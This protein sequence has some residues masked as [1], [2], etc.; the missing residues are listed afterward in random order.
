MQEH[1]KYYPKPETVRTIIKRRAFC[2]TFAV[3]I[4]ARFNTGETTY[5]VQPSNIPMGGPYTVTVQHPSPTPDA[6]YGPLETYYV[7]AHGARC[8]VGREAVQ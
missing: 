4:G 5:H 6:I 8:D 1:P 7:N 3:N 2:Q